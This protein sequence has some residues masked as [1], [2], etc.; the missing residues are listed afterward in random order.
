MANKL[1]PPILEA[2]I[3]AFCGTQVAI[4]FAPNPLVTNVDYQGFTLQVKKINSELVGVYNS[5][6]YDKENNIVYFDLKTDL[7]ENPNW[8]KF[9]L[10]YNNDQIGYYSTVAVGRFLGQNMPTLQLIADSAGSYKAVYN[11]PIDITEKA[12]SFHFI[13]KD[14]YDEVIEDLGEQI[15]DINKD[16]EE[17]TSIEFFEFKYNLQAS[18]IKYFLY[19]TVKTINGLILSTSIHII[20][21]ILS[22]V[23]L[24]ED[25]DD[26]FIIEANLNRDNGTVKLSVNINRKKEVS[27]LIGRY[28]IK[29]TCSKDNYLR[30]S[31]I[32][33]FSLC[34]SPD[35]K[36]M[37]DNYRIAL[38]ED[39]T[40]EAGYYY[41]YYIQR[42]NTNGIYSKSIGTTDYPIYVSFDDC[43]LFDGERQLCIQYNPKISSFKTNI[44]Q[45]KTEA[46]GSKYPYII[47]N[48][49]INYK[50]FPISGLISFNMDKNNLFMTK[51]DKERLGIMPDNAMR[52]KYQAE[53]PEYN[54]KQR[55]IVK[56][57]QRG[58]SQNL[59]DINIS[60]EKEFKLMVLDFLNSPKPKLFRSATEGNYCVYTMNSS[61]SPNDALGRML[62]TFN[63]TAYEIMD[64]EDF[65][66]ELIIQ[67]GDIYD[68]EGNLLSLNGIEDYNQKTKTLTYT[69]VEQMVNK[70]L[71]QYNEFVRHFGIRDANPLSQYRLTF[72][73]LANPAEKINDQIITVGS[74]GSYN[75]FTTSD[76]I[77][78]K[79]IFILPFEQEVYNSNYVAFILKDYITIDYTD[80]DYLKNYNINT[81]LGNQ[82]SADK[83]QEEQIIT[84][85]E[86]PTINEDGSITKSAINNL[87]LFRVENRN[88]SE[89]EYAQYCFDNNYLINQELLQV[90]KEVGKHIKNPESRTPV[91]DYPFTVY[92]SEDLK[93]YLLE[94]DF[95]YNIIEK[96]SANEKAKILQENLNTSFDVKYKI[97]FSGYEGSPMSAPAYKLYN[98]LIFQIEWQTKLIPPSATLNLLISAG[99]I[100]NIVV[101]YDNDNKDLFYEVFCDTTFAEY[102]YGG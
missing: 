92:I 18:D 81:D 49:I 66:K 100:P 39:K 101:R 8:Y 95:L 24:N 63:C 87:Y 74:T 37:S 14:G 88:T 64:V 46:I 45:A 82:I 51:Y 31:T 38:L 52:G 78:I 57:L 59:V 10:A 7:G 20:D 42:Y 19:C 86:P 4:P 67:D 75:Y 22:G 62:H 12:Y 70:N 102:Y 35:P 6:L 72:I 21:S 94:Y 65:Y 28:V 56:T 77:Y 30:I 73:N 96:L 26:I 32:S 68:S 61:L 83:A 84:Y 25:L 5:Y 85:L 27:S 34:T 53:Y 55:R 33:Y 2:S 23:T 3:P 79:G 47:R 41:K 54:L 16:E 29:R 98:L 17:D 71:L 40:V 76:Y 13:L 44:Q 58:T 36:N 11:H 91:F 1:Y 43:F 90:K 9:Q 80:F 15:H 93:T 60:A 89:V 69:N 50:E 48:S 97:N 99:K